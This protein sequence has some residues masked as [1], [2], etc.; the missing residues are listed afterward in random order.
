VWDVG[1]WNTKDDYWNPSTVRQSFTDLA[2][3][4]PEAQAAY[5][6]G[7]HGGKDAFGRT[8]TNPA[9][10]DLADGT[11]WDGLGLTDN[12]WVTATYLWTAGGTPV[13]TWPTVGQGASGERVKTIQYLLN[14]RGAGL[15][16]DGEF[17]PATLAAVKG[18]QTAQ[19]LSVDGVVGP[20]TWGALVETVQFGSTGQAVRAVQS[21]LTAHGI[22]TT[23]SGTFDATTQANVE[24]FQ[25]ASGLTASG[26]VDAGTWKSLV[27]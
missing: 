12:T 15:S 6:N 8:V 7:Y 3:G 10:I 25:T 9:G 5:Q 20:N 14:D 17:G 26:T 16:V 27:A 4:L 23:V 21:Q 2:Q 1:P 19:K 13:A 11:F 18:F 24:Q 22:A